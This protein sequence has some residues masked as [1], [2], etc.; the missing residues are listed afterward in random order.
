MR[1]RYCGLLEIM[2]KQMIEYSI[3]YALAGMFL[4]ILLAA[5][6]K[7]GMTEDSIIQFAEEHRGMI[8]FIQAYTALKIM[9]L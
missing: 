6:I 2:I 8:C 7:F 4:M 9:E 3:S 1:G 5:P